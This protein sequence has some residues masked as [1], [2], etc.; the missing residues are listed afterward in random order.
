MSKKLLFNYSFDA[1]EKTIVVKDEFISQKE[2]LL[3]TNVTDGKIIYNFSNSTLG[4]TSVTYD[5][6]TGD[7]TI[8]L[9]YDTTG[10]SDNDELQIYYDKASVE[11]E[12]VESLIDPVSK[13]RVSNPN[14]LVDTD[15][16]YGPQSTKWETIELVENI[17]LFFTRT[18]SLI[19]DVE[20][21]EV[22][23]GSNIVTVST[24]S[25]HGLAVGFPIDIRAT[26]D[27]SVDGAFVVD[28][29]VGINTFTYKL[30]NSA[31]EDYANAKE[32]YTQVYVGEFFSISD[33]KLF[34]TS[35]Q[36]TIDPTTAIN[37]NIITSSNHGFSD[38]DVVQY[39]HGGGNDIVGIDSRGLYFV[40][41][42]TDNTFALSTSKNG[43]RISIS[44]GSGSNHKFSSIIGAFTDAGSPT[45]E[46]FIKTQTKNP[47]ST[48]FPVYLFGTRDG[49]ADDTYNINEVLNDTTVSVASTQEVSERTL[50]VYVAAAATGIVTAISGTPFYSANHGFIEGQMLVYEPNLDNYGSGAGNTALESLNKGDVYFTV[51][52]GQDYFSL[53]ASSQD[54]AAGTVIDLSDSAHTAKTQFHQFKFKHVSGLKQGT[55]TVGVSTVGNQSQLTGT[56]SKFLADVK[57]GDEVV[58]YDT[59][60]SFTSS[61]NEMYTAGSGT[62][63]SRRGADNAIYE[64]ARNTT[65][66][67]MTFGNGTGGAAAVPT[68]ANG[69]PWVIGEIIDYRGF[70]TGNTSQ[71]NRDYT[72]KRYR[73]AGNRFT[74]GSSHSNMPGI[75]T[76]YYYVHSVNT[77]GNAIRLSLNPALNEFVDVTSD[78]VRTYKTR[79][80]RFIIDNRREIISIS[81][82]GF[83]TGNQVEY[84]VASGGNPINGLTSGKT[85][86]V[87]RYTNNT[88]GLKHVAGQGT[89]TA[90]TTVTVVWSGMSTINNDHQFTVS[91]LTAGARYVREITAVASDTVATMNQEISSGLS[92]GTNFFT[93]TRFIP[94]S[95]G[96]AQHRP[97]DGGMEIAT[98]QPFKGAHMIRQT[99]KYFRYQSGKGLQISFAVN[100][101]PPSDID[102]LG[103][104]RQEL[105]GA[106]PGS[107]TTTLLELSST[108]GFG[109]TG[110]VKVDSEE[111]YYTGINSLG[112]TIAARAQNG[113]SE[114]A[115]TAGTKAFGISSESMSG[116]GV[117]SFY[118]GLVQYKFPHGISSTSDYSMP[119]IVTIGAT[120]ATGDNVYGGG[121][122]LPVIEIH[123]TRTLSVSLGTSEATQLTASGLVRSY[124]PSWN[125]SALRAGMFDFQNGMFFEYDGGTLYFVRRNSTV[126]LSGKISGTKGSNVLT[127]TETRFTEQLKIGDRLVL[128]G[129]TYKVQNVNSDVQLE[130]TPEFRS[131]STGGIIPIKT[132]ELRVSQ[133]EWNIDKM[134]G[135]GPSGY[136]LDLSRIQM[137]YIDYSWYGAG[138]IRF[139][140]KDLNGK[141]KYAHRMIH[142]NNEVIAYFR[143]G[144]LPTRYEVE[145]T[146]SSN[147]APRLAHWGVS[148]I[149][150][151]EF[152]DDQAYLFNKTS[153]KI[154]PTGEQDSATTINTFYGTLNEVLDASET[155]IDISTNQSPNY[156]DIVD[157]TY[158]LYVDNEL[159]TFT[160]ISFLGQFTSKGGFLVKRYR[161]TGCTRGAGSSSA[162]SH[163]NRASIE[164][165]N[166]ANIGG[167]IS[168]FE[169]IEFPIL[170]VRL[171]PSV[172]SGV[173][174]LFGQRD[175]INRMQMQ[176]QRID[177]VASKEC[178]IDLRL[179]T[180]L[181][182]S[183]TDFQNNDLPSI[184]QFLLHNASGSDVVKGGDKIFGINL[185]TNRVSSD[186]TDIA[187]LGNAIVGGDLTFP[188]GPDILTVVAKID[189]EDWTIGTDYIYCTLNWTES[190][191]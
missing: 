175:I 149:M 62:N 142:N 38:N 35:T 163:N 98:N 106:V 148:V 165:S 155:Q 48:S 129:T 134:D 128:R 178:S 70:S 160:G 55:G 97:Y 40:D 30:S 37:E 161:L 105:N 69:G 25:S 54:A 135:T 124:V 96:Y 47:L 103:Y 91:G 3:I 147:Y 85:Y 120:V 168:A 50:E 72:G 60:G 126:K 65:N 146:S 5:A 83:S 22:E 95:E 51:S 190:Q 152:E 52:K 32:P 181:G 49:V 184:S 179:N 157:N 143:S 23:T 93:P 140:F 2:L 16:E 92:D 189:V 125:G 31:V 14:T 127:G 36:V 18:D 101:K 133:S 115:H 154:F 90:G 109:T 110:I 73:D 41:Y 172:D 113:T 156:F 144:N 56:G 174:G 66:D 19:S 82:H 186:L 1:S 80:R 187:P 61:V 10:M 167:K 151:G 34:N 71:E 27:N 67:F 116:V 102:L 166:S 78:N 100:F 150:D 132:E 8:V 159:V 118:R 111:F 162:A 46:L 86:E 141:V 20:T 42:I 121:A 99:R 170:S 173:P 74:S 43:D 12:P 136:T 188:E 138:A 122:E 145:N 107:G 117:G 9:V 26:K 45:S 28:T 11:F 139:G 185:D 79:L 81:N 76:T 53:A 4:A 131:E 112:L 87:V 130:V 7:T 108:V 58:I 94:R 123:D 153:R 13:I 104:P 77:A 17:P 29:V 191:A 21:I 57:I 176:L 169:G 114:A 89:G 15:F 137:A 33:L 164:L 182:N 158:T 68:A 84:T 64:N 6:N 39:T 75:T 88:F 177:M 119:S 44:G 183:F 59:T 180:R 24:A 171:A 63:P